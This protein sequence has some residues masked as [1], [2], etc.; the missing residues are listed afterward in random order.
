LAD[1]SEAGRLKV[2]FLASWYP[3]KEHP[4]S[5][6]F[7]KRHAI[8][9]STYC[10]IA[11]LYVHLGD[12]ETETDVTRENN[13]IEV[14]VYRKRHQYNNKWMKYFYDYAQ[15]YFD[16]LRAEF[17]G[18][19]IIEKEF[20][21]PDLAHVNVILYSGL[22]G[23]ALKFLRGI[24]YV[25]T[26]HWAGYLKEDGTF[27]RRSSVGKYI[28]RAVGDK[29]L[30]LM[31][32]SCSLRDAMKACGIENRFFVVPNVV[33]VR[34][35]STDPVRHGDKKIIIHISLLKDEV[36]NVS[37]IIEAIRILKQKR[38]DFELHLIGD[39]NDRKKL[40]D[41]ASNYGLLNNIIYFHGMVDADE[42]ENFIQG[43]DFSIINSKF[44]TFSVSAAESLICGKPV[45]A[46]RCGGPE[47]FVNDKCGIL[48]EKGDVEGLARA[49]DYMLDNYGRYDSKE[50]AKYAKSRFSSLVVGKMIYDVY[51]SVLNSKPK[52]QTQ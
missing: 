23:L 17:I 14:R 22:M 32:V 2:L 43:S 45:I 39:G 16:F 29:A 27:Y 50:I 36:K 12:I 34:N 30:A 8:A 31:A 47:E 5:G 48:V 24:P 28:I 4:V 21:R 35:V 3:N 49:M 42:V 25:V 40:E 18:Y 13:L 19:R 15:F 6:I 46:T 9:V 26:E 37:G 10:D 20:G 7:V 52:N 1:K 11:V 38:T 51:K 33:D 44:E 41:M